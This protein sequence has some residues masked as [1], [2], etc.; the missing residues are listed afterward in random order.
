MTGNR[1]QHPKL[2][3]IEARRV[4]KDG[5]RFFVITDP[6]RIASQV[7]M[8]REELGGFLALADGAM[9]VDEIIAS[10]RSQQNGAS[11]VNDGA[12][13]DMFERLDSLFL[14]DGDRY[15]GEVKRQLQEYRSVEFRRPVL[16]GTAYPED[17]D[18]LLDLFEGF[19]P[20]VSDDQER[21]GNRL[22]AIVSPHIDFT[23]GGDTYA[24]TWRRAAPDLEDVE[25]A[26]ILGTDHNGAGPRL[27][28]TRQNY[29][30]PWNIMPT[31][32][33]LV[34]KLAKVLEVD[35]AVKNHPFSDEF[36]HVHE[37]SIELASI[38]LN[39][40][41]GDRAVKMLPILCGSLGQYVREDGSLRD[42][43]PMDHPQIADAIGLLQ[44]TALHRKTVFIAAADLSHVGP[45][46][47]DADAADEEARNEI[48]EY[49]AELMTSI[50]KGD[51]QAFLETV[52]SYGDD[53]RIC[54]LAPLYMTLWAAGSSDGHWMGYQQCS[55]DE[56]GSSF[57]SI[58]G[59]LLY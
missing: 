46:F 12:V 41:V 19:A 1:L 6:R 18:E 22:R 13:R 21:S 5:E 44:Q 57:V 35:N 50:I 40:A 26:V 4:E 2:R 36:N 49:D 28:L 3:N 7:L 43:S 25:L 58:A 56:Q 27:T 48:E 39:W 34:A 37:H 15:E 47:G 42:A 9:T 38:W 11:T 17:P 51:Q 31:D 54:G 10:V 45:A 24:E 33:E 30:T 20:D 55:A 53:S 16:E 23:R 59:G 14:L 8:V 29:A 32:A 52:R